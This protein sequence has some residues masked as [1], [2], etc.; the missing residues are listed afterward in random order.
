MGNTIILLGNGADESASRWMKAAGIAIDSE[1]YRKVAIAY[2]K[3]L[4]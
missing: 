4:H 3:N 1:H 2:Q